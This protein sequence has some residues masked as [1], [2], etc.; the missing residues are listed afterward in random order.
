MMRVHGSL[1][2]LLA[3]LLAVSLS[4][5]T[6]LAQQT[7]KTPLPTPGIE[8]T[9]PP[10]TEE[11]SGASQLRVDVDPQLGLELF[12]VSRGPD[13]FAANVVGGGD[14]AASIGG[15]CLDGYTSVD[16]AL[17]MVWVGDS[18]PVDIEF[19]TNT[20]DQ[21]AAIWL[22]ELSNGQWWCTTTYSN[23]S[24]LGFTNLAQGVHFIWIVTETLGQVNGKL[25]VTQGP[26]PES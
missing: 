3:V 4:A 10:S 11:V 6:A 22:W 17:A 16:A 26:E 23:R 9:L 14:I 12:A 1:V 24:T 21:T 25:K 18:G 20:P 5:L 19:L 2:R 8:P 13:Y 15:D 7:T